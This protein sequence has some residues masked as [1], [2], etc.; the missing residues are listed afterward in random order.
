[1]TTKEIRMSRLRAEI[2]ILDVSLN[3]NI[4]KHPPHKC[5]GIPYKHLK[6]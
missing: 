3:Q 5:G 4:I 1:M 2:L 6:S